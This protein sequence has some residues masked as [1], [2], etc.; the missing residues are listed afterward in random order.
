LYIIASDGMGWE[1]VSVHVEHFT[2]DDPK[3]H[4]YTPYWEE[5]HFVKRLFW[6]DDDIVMQ[7]HPKKSDYVNV[8]PHVLHL[9]RPTGGWIVPLPEIILV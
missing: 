5:M 3:I 6:D 8:H 4:T 9:W 7:I 2:D 1:H